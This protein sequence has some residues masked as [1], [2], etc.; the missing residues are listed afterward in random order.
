MVSQGSQRVGIKN[1][2][3]LTKLLVLRVDS[4]SKVG[5]A[6]ALLF[7]YLLKYFVL[8]CLK[9]PKNRKWIRKNDDSLSSR[10]YVV[11]YYLRI[12]MFGHINSN[13]CFAIVTFF[14]FSVGLYAKRDSNT[15]SISQ[16]LFFLYK[17]YFSIYT[18]Y[19]I[20]YIQQLY[21]NIPYISNKRNLEVTLSKKIK[22]LILLREIVKG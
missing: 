18:I 13:K 12:L 10:L 5:N 1:S 17:N 22:F 11:D 16:S 3:T 19:S 9:K 7:Y 2:I 21:S 6:F 15:F 4:L 20:Q 8:T 14:T